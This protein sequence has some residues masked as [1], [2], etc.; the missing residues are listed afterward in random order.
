MKFHIADYTIV[1]APAGMILLAV[2]ILLLVVSIA[3]VI[4]VV[5]RRGR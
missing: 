1:L 3:V 5:Q 2:C 4:R